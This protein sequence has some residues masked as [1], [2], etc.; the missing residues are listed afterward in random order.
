MRLEGHDQWISGLVFSP[1]GKYLFSSC[2]DKS[3]RI[4]DLV[5][6]GVCFRTLSNLHNTFIS[7]L[8]LNSKLMVTADVDKLIKIW[9]IR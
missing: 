2:E 9:E 1:N 4:W 6:N 5:N 3:V 7:C 8:A